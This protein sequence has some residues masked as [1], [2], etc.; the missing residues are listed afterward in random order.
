MGPLSFTDRGVIAGC[1]AAPALSKLA[2]YTPLKTVQETGLSAGLDSWIHDVTIDAEDKDPQRA[3]QQIVSLYRTVS[4]ELGHAELQIS[5]S[6]SAFVCTDRQTQ[7]RVQQLLREGEPPVLHLVKDLG[8]DSA[9]ARRR[10]VASSN[11]RLAKATGRSSKLTRLKITNPKKRAQVAATGVFTAATFGHQGQGISP[12]RM[13]VLRAIAGGHYGKMA[14]G[15]L[16]LLFDLSW[17]GSGDPLFKIILEHWN[18]L[19]ECVS[20][21]L[22]ASRLIR[23]TWTVS[24]QKLARSPQRWKLA[25]GP[26]AAMQCYLMD[27]GLDA[28]TMDEWKKEG[29]TIN[30]AWGSPRVGVGSQG[31]AAPSYAC[32]PV[33]AH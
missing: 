7:A 14:F 29:T 26:I 19:Q 24:W 15:S 33:G 16:D 1:P 32:R 10:R 25:A 31:E 23:R 4:A 11:A 2:L 9:G 13:K 3:A 5:T 27:M 21:N 22:P 30:L 17:L 6:K 28:P 18:M 8:V 20:R 12:R